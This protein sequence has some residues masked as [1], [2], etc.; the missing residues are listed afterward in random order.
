LAFLT[1]ARRGALLF[2]AM[3][4]LASCGST[5]TASDTV[6]GGTTATTTASAFPV[7][8]KH[9]FGTTTVPTKPERIAVVGLTEQDT[10]LAL[11]EQPIATTEWYG[12]HPSAV[13]P[14]AQKALGDAKPTVLSSADGLQ[15]ERIAALRPDLILG[16]NAG[17]RRGDWEK[18]SKIAPTVA[19]PVGST[20]YFA[21]WDQQAQLIATAMGKEAEGRALVQ[22]V[23][24]QY[25]KVAAEHPDFRGKTVTFSQNAFYDGLIYVYPEGLNTEF[26]TY[27]GFTIN[28]RVTALAT[29]PG[30]QVSISP[31]RLGVLDADVAVFATEKPSDVAALEKVPT[32][33]KLAVV[34]D[35]RAVFTDATLAGAMYFMT[36]LSL[37]YVLDRLAPQ[38][39]AAIDGEAPRRVVDTSDRR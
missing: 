22:D 21:P 33:D 37:P 17:L 15:Y 3:L 9:K 12:E 6:T 25:A 2:A 1:F 28:P 7:S 24:D 34:A 26:L 27:L 10:V 4:I 32:F 13:W 35:H 39:Q 18:L 19:A 36:P 8:V 16:V 23:K 29:T 30:E 38:L 20:D 11:G 31:E 5:E 14:W